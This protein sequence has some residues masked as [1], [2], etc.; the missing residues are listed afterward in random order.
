MIKIAR[1]EDEQL[2]AKQLH[3]Y[4]RKYE[5]ENGEAQLRGEAPAPTLY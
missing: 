4:L 5:K 3:E 2:Y 1:V